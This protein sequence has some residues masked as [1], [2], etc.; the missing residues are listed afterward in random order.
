MSVLASGATAAVATASTK[1]PASDSSA[2]VIFKT[3]KKTTTTKPKPK[4]KKK[5]KKKK[6]TT[7]TR[8]KSTTTTAPKTQTTTETPPSG[9]YTISEDGSSLLLPLFQLWAQAY[10]KAYSNVTVNPSG[11]GS[12]KGVSDAA[13]GV[14]NIGA[15]DAYL[16]NTQLSVTPGL[17]NIALAISSQMIVTNIQGYGANTHI[18]LTGQVI[19]QIYQ[20]KISYWDDSAIQNLNPNVNLPHQ[21]I[22]ALHRIDSSGDTFIFTQ[23]LSDADPNGWGSSVSYGTTVSFPA[24]NNAAGESGNGGM[25]TG[26]NATPGCIAYIGISYE[27]QVKGD[28]LQVNSISNASGN[29]EQPTPSSITSEAHALEAQT[30]A[31]ETLSMI[32]D[33]ASDGYPI[34]NYEYAIVQ[35]SQSN[36][37]QAAAMRAFLDWAVDPANGSNNSF[38]SQVGFIPLTPAVQALTV[39]QIAKIGS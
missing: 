19:S 25:V 20:G 26:C 33:N 14:V 34:V 3:K 24:I 30:P 28:G 27:S 13:G 4:K 11:G 8:P 12:G 29:Y 16:S 15:S 38:L 21:Q 17:M 7:T 18:N 1:A 5:K 9:N 22:V 10:G 37:N 32:Y 2:N 36:S 6:T 23:Y 31:N 39:A 35:R